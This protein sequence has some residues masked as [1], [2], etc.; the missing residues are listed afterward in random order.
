MYG[1]LLI[2]KSAMLDRSSEEEVEKY[3]EFLTKYMSLYLPENT[4][5]KEK[6]HKDMEEHFNF[7]FRNEEGEVKTIQMRVGD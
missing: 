2:A 5:D 6:V 3:N 4:K 7:M 1:T